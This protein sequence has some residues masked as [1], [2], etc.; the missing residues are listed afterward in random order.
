MHCTH[1]T[2]VFIVIRLIHSLQSVHGQQTIKTKGMEK[3]KAHTH[4]TSIHLI[5]KLGQNASIFEVKHNLLMSRALKSVTFKSQYMSALMAAPFIGSLLLRLIRR[6]FK[7]NYMSIV[8]VVL[9]VLSFA[10]AILCK[11]HQLY[12]SSETKAA[13]TYLSC[14]PTICRTRA[15]LLPYTNI[16]LL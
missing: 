5:H 8:C 14:I 4:T 2:D 6:L 15:S 1:I 9:P 10:Y 7:V 16:S 11:I 13:L 12:F 3:T